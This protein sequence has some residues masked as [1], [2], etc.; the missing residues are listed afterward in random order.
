MNRTVDR[1]VEVLRR[2]GPGALSERHLAG[3]LLRCSP[4]IRLTAREL[5]RILKDSE[6]RLA[7]LEITADDAGE[8][9]LDSWIVLMDPDDGP[10][11][12]WLATMLW[13]SLAAMAAEVNPDS[14][15]DVARW[16]GHAERAG[17]LLM[18][19]SRFGL[20]EP[21]LRYGKRRR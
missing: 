13:R 3:E 6:G 18:T 17:R 16:I 8:M 5:D 19:A 1:V 4:P 14:R 11:R 12:P 15:T 2:T 21:D 10:T 7:R 20:A 9:I